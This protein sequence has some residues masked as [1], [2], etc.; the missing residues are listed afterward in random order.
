METEAAVIA[1]VRN[2]RDDYVGNDHKSVSIIAVC[3]GGVSIIV[4]LRSVHNA[5]WLR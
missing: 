2:E 1:G 3:G 4:I 5:R